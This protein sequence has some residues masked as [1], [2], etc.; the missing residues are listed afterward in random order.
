[1]RFTARDGVFKEFASW[2]AN[3]ICE[4]Y[5]NSLSGKCEIINAEK[6]NISVKIFIYMLLRV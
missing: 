6:Q 4:Y 1:M 5:C 2:L 3:N